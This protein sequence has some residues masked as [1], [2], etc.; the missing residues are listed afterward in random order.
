MEGMCYVRGPNGQSISGH[1]V[2]IFF[3]CLLKGKYFSAHPLPQKRIQ[4][5]NGVRLML[6]WL[7]LNHDIDQT[8]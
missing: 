2:G 5:S 4:C 3:S 1:A 7:V 8:V 6:L